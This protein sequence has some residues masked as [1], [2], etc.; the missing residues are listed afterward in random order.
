MVWCLI[1]LS[2][3]VKL[4]MKGL[5]LGFYLICYYSTHLFYRKLVK[6]IVWLVLIV[7]FIFFSIPKL[8]SVFY[9]CQKTIKLQSPQSC[10]NSL[11]PRPIEKALLTVYSVLQTFIF[12][13][14]LHPT[15]ILWASSPSKQAKWAIW[16]VTWLLMINC[17]LGP[18]V[19]QKIDNNA[20][21][22]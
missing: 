12:Y 15:S 7:V 4:L 17:T 20:H 5:I 18:I 8:L 19:I 13:L 22:G 1:L 14:I 11:P 10:L 21:S 3:L 9:D 6:S 16:E 2:T